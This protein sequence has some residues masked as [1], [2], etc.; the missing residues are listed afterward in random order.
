MSNFKEAKGDPI[1]ST[2]R[3]VAESFVRPQVGYS[4]KVGFAE[5]NDKRML[6]IDSVRRLFKKYFEESDNYFELRFYRRTA[7]TRANGIKIETLVATFDDA[8]CKL[9]G[10]FENDRVIVEFVKVL[11]QTGSVDAAYATVSKPSFQ[12]ND[13]AFDAKCSFEDL[14]AQRDYLLLFHEQGIVTKWFLKLVNLY[15]PNQIVSTQQTP[16]A[17]QVGHISNF[18]AQQFK[19]QNV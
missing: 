14:I 12:G 15:F 19:P 17:H 5:K 8:E 13:F 3:H 18:V 6:F 10:G 4:K 1:D 16:P 11:Y 9:S 7:A 2:Y